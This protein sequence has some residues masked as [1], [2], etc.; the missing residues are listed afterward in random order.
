[1]AV[2]ARPVVSDALRPQHSVV[3][4]RDRADAER[5]T[6]T[7]LQELHLSGDTEISGAFGPLRAKQSKP[8]RDEF[9]VVRLKEGAGVGVSR[10]L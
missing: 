10:R 4:R 6:H 2:A 7:I 3:Q 8:P 9:G 1:M 5:G